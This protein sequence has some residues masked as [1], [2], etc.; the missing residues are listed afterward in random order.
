MFDL[1]KHS[2]NR[3]L[4]K[5]TFVAGVAL[6]A[7]VAYASAYDPDPPPSS[8]GPND[9]AGNTNTQTPAKV[10]E[11]A[12]HIKSG[13]KWMLGHPYN[14]NMP[15]LPGTSWTL[16]LPSPV[17]VG[18][19]TDNIDGFDG[20]IAQSGTQF[21]ALGHVGWFAGTTTN[22][23]DALYY[24]RFTGADVHGPNGLRKLGV[25]KL[26]PFFTTAILLDMRRYGNAGAILPDGLKI[27]VPMVLQVLAAQGLS[28]ADIEPGDVVLFYTGWDEHWDDG[29]ANY[30]KGFPFVPGGTPGIGLEVAQWLGD[31]GVAC[32]GADNWAVEVVDNLD[33]FNL[34]P[35]PIPVHHE[36]LVKR[37][38]P[39]HE[40][41]R[42]SELAADLA[43]EYELTPSPKVYKMAYIYAPVPIEGATGSP[44]VPMAVK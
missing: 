21:D 13:R 20:S 34:P 5:V 27:T 35:L 26:K 25:E 23:N 10:L 31:K 22:L 41:M 44:G 3:I 12:K 18:Q 9:E 2:R 29:T 39:L 42:L 14:S 40:N 15:F 36:L 24:N 43:A 30:Y 38:I 8:W 28:P 32:V 17:I 16:T 6:C 7:G 11:A 19:Q 1:T 33:F 4:T 37:G